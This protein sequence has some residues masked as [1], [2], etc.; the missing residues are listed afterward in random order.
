M[1]DVNHNRTNPPG[2]DPRL[3]LRDEELDYG[4]SLMLTAER[5]LMKQAGHIAQKHAMPPL[6]ARVL[7]SIRFLP[8]Q[9]VKALREQL[10]ATTPTLARILGDLGKRGLIDR[11]PSKTDARARA[12]FLTEEGKRLTDPATIAMRDTLR[13][14]YRRAGA[15]AVAGARSVLEA[16]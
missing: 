10:D 8:G 9:T 15:S 16:L 11:Q 14:A 12:L 13:L 6:A 7:I 4:I 5:V 3:F 2:F 1:A